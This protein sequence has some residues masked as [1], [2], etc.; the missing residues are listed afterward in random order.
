MLGDSEDINTRDEN[1]IQGLINSM[2]DKINIIE[3]LAPNSIII[4]DKDGHLNNGNLENIDAFKDLQ[5]QI[6]EHKR[7]QLSISGTGN[8]IGNLTVSDGAI[9]ATKT[10]VGNLN[11][12]DYAL[13]TDGTAITNSD[14]INKALSK[15]QVQINTVVGNQANDL[16][17]NFSSSGEGDYISTLLLDNNT[18]TLSATI[19]KLADG[20]LSNYDISSSDINGN[21]N[22]TDSI[23]K[24]I[25][26]LQK[27]INNIVGGEG[28]VNSFTST[29]SGNNVAGLVLSNGKLTATLNNLTSVNL[30]GFS[31]GTATG[32]IAATD[33]LGTALSKL[34]ANITA[35]KGD[36][37]VFSSVENNY[38]KIF[39]QE[40]APTGTL[41]SGWI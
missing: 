38:A 34:Q 15:L 11:L 27:Q 25:A 31:Q 1:T 20:I 37:Y 41:K 18:K 16:V 30:A 8:L 40:A 36:T 29:G 23:V 26:K 35:M 39:R 4:S 13:G 3:D 14:T 2:R 21:V 10:N 7:T 28:A 19:G 24:A 5:D 33:S 9:T 22:N 32:A 17:Q 12:T 6:K